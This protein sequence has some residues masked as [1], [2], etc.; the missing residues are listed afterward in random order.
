FNFLK[1]QTTDI[2]YENWTYDSEI[3]SIQLNVNG[4]IQSI[5]VLRLNSSD[6]MTLEFDEVGSET[7]NEFYYKIIHCDK[8]WQPSSI[9]PIEYIDGFEEERIRDWQLS[10][11]T[12]LE[13]VHYWQT[14]PSRD[15]KIK[16]SG[17]Y[18]LLVYNKNNENSPLFTRRF[19]VSEDLVYA[20]ARWNRPTDTEFI[21]F[22]QQ[23]FL[24]FTTKN[25]RL[26]N[27][28][29]DVKVDII[30]NGDW[31]NAMTNVAPRNL[32]NGLF[33]FDSYGLINFWGTNEYRSFDTRTLRGRGIG[34]RKIENFIDGYDV[35][36]YQNRLKENSVYSFTFDFNGKFYIDNIDLFD[37]ILFDQSTATANQ[38]GSFRNS[39][40]YF[41]ET[42]KDW[43]AKEKEIRSDYANIIFTLETD[44]L[45]RD[46]YV[47]G[48]FT[49]FQLKPEYKMKYDDKRGMYVSEALLK[50][51]YYDYLFAQPSKDGR[52]DFRITEGTWQDTENEYKII[53]YLSEFGARYDRVIGVVNRNSIDF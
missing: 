32:N 7:D 1:S 12:K 52:P 17:N 31:K 21:R 5:P 41:D 42:N 24:E 19:I 51:G 28:M 39:F 37:R 47:Y 48:S 45:D 8:T 9:Q 34:V 15:T 27:G 46:V 22:K 3:K 36:L 11:D 23:L 50:Q 18:I 33:S 44:K 25:L 13:F 14:I 53:V 6:I 49:D 43:Q 10:I 26:L 20:N 35:Y 38:L 2:K 29:R 4:I 40:A 30:Q 16:I